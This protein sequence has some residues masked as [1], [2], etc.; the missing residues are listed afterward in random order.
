VVCHEERHLGMPGPL[1]IARPASDTTHPRS[2]VGDDSARG[3]AI[4]TYKATDLGRG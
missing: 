2:A 1:G 4:R 3:D